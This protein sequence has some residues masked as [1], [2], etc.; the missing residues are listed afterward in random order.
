MKSKLVPVGPIFRTAISGYQ[1]HNVGRMAGSIAFS[2]ILSLGPMVVIL[3]AVAGFVFGRS[4]AEGLVLRRLQGTLGHQ[5]ASALQGMIGGA[6]RSRASIPA[7]AVATLVL[8]WSAS[9]LVAN[10]RGSLNTIWEVRSGGGGGLKGFAVG[11]AFDVATM[12]ALAGLLLISLAANTA[13]SA[14]NHYF[15]EVIPFSGARLVASGIVFSLIVATAVFAIVFRWLSGVRLGRREL[16]LGSA[17]SAILFTVGNYFLSFYL[18]RSSPGS[19]FGAAGSLV[20]IILWMYYSSFM[21]LFGAEVTRAYW[22]HRHR[23]LAGRPLLT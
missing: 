22:Q 1:R 8:I 18:A 10:M 20:V 7:T 21:V 5:A 9:Q 6:Y 13:V 16:M 14:L 2:G 15:A 23:G 12:F 19:V 11:K 3:V 17:L 4:A